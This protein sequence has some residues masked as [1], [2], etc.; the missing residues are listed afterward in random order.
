MLF[1]FRFHFLALNSVPPP[2]VF[3]FYFL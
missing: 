1:F 3:F 2:A